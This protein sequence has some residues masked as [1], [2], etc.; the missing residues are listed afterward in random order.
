MTTYIGKKIL[1]TSGGTLEKWDEVRGHTN[2]AKGT[3]GVYLA[4]EALQR[5]AEVIYLHGYFAH[6]PP[7]NPNLRLQPF[8]GIDDLAEQIRSLV[9]TEP[10]DAV[11]M[12]AAVSD[13]VIDRILDP[14][15]NPLGEHGKLSSDTPPVIHFKK[16]PK[17]I[18]AIKTWNADVLLVGFK[19]EHT[20]DVDHLLN[21]AK[22]RMETWRADLTVANASSSLYTEETPHYIVTPSGDYRVCANKKDTASALLDT[23]SARFT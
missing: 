8:M 17:V 14:E 7:R 13:W 16:A 15:G 11:I 9:T 5:G 21:R 6:V 12:T 18:T 2:L 19:L 10:I 23:L 22:M 20:T 1:I 4:Q 3:M